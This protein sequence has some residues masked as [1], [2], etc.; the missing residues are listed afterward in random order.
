MDEIKFRDM[1]WSRV[2]ASSFSFKMWSYTY[3]SAFSSGNI[4][5]GV[6]FL[7]VVDVTSSSIVGNSIFIAQSNNSRLFL[8]LLASYCDVTIVRAKYI[9]FYILLVIGRVEN[10]S[11]NSELLVLGSERPKVPSARPSAEP[12]IVHALC[13]SRTFGYVHRK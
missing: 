7:I 5:G 11:E 1:R 3:S 9:L 2:M 6:E 12:S 8:W 4:C 10:Q 13:R